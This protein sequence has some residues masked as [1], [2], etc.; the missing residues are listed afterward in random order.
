MG[1]SD[2]CAVTGLIWAGRPAPIIAQH[3]YLKFLLYKVTTS[4]KS[5]RKIDFAPRL[6]C[7]KCSNILFGLRKLRLDLSQISPPT[8]RAQTPLFAPP[9]S[10]RFLDDS[11]S[12]AEEG[13]GRAGVAEQPALVDPAARLDPRRPLRHRLLP[14]A[15]AVP[16]AVSF[17][18]AA[19]DAR[20]GG[21][22]LCWPRGRDT[23]RGRR[24]RCSPGALA[25][26]L[27]GRAV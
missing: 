21:R 14:A 3:V 27:Q 4:E 11:R 17:R 2:G 12:D 25:C 15:C 1:K 24:R 8:S 18:S 23:R 7:Y 9:S 19:T 5:V 10:P 22:F 26:R 13:E 6:L 16:Q 20:A